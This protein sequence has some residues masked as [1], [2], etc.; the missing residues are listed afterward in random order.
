MP[1]SKERAMH[2]EPLLRPPATMHPTH[3]RTMRR[4]KRQVQGVAIDP[5]A[6]RYEIAHARSMRGHFVGFADTEGA[7]VADGASPNKH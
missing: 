6:A 4:A 5:C 3:T 1:K 7:G 2:S